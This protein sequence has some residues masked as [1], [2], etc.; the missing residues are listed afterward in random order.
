MHKFQRGRLLP[1]LV[2]MLEKK[3]KKKREMVLF[4]QLG[5]AQRFHRLG[6]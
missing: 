3:K 5:S 2:P 1:N 4:S 6:L